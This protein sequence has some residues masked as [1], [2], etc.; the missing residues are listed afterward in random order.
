[1]IRSCRSSS[2]RASRAPGSWPRQSRALLTVAQTRQFR[3]A[4]APRTADVSAD[5]RSVAFESLARLVPADTDDRLDIYVLD[6]RRGRVTLE[7]EVLGDGAE[8]SH[9]RISGDGRY[10]VFES[11][12]ADYHEHA[13]AHDI[14]LRDRTAGTSRVLTATARNTA[15][16]G[17]SRDPDISDDGRVVAFSS[18]A[19]TLTDGPDANGATRR[20]LPRRA[21]GRRRSAA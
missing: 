20:R 21:A 3:S 7:S 1:M 6:R 2:L 10:L 18:A 17:W 11:R 13:R 14:V 19:T 8:H 12:P 4:R 5:G 16:F 15:P 9:P